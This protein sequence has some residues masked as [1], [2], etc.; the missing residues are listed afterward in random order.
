ML[1][2]PGSTTNLVPV[3][4]LSMSAVKKPPC[5]R[6]VEPRLAFICTIWLAPK[7]MNSA[8][9]IET[10]LSVMTSSSSSRRLEAETAHSA[11]RCALDSVGRPPKRRHCGT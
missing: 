3:E 10:L 1:V 7:G 11:A 9:T 5:T 6:S 8:M 4:S 2:R